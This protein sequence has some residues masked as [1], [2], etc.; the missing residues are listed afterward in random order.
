MSVVCNPDSRMSVHG[1]LV[2]TCKQ[3]ECNLNVS[4]V[5]GSIANANQCMYDFVWS[6]QLLPSPIFRIICWGKNLPMHKLAWQLEPLQ[7]LDSLCPSVTS[8]GRSKEEGSSLSHRK[9]PCVQYACSEACHCSICILVRME[10]GNIFIIAKT[11][12]FW[13]TPMT[14]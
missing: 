3:T 11:T 4:R 10:R 12:R 14:V 5:R 7:L 6:M 13:M 9:E 1:L 2:V 8:H